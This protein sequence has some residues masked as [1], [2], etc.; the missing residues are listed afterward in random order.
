MFAISGVGI[1]VF[2]LNAP[3]KLIFFICTSVLPFNNIIFRSLQNFTDI[4]SYF[5]QII[6]L[7]NSLG[8]LVNPLC[9]RFFFN[10]FVNVF[11]TTILNYSLSYFLNFSYTI[12]HFFIYYILL[13][14]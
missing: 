14:N 7:N 5:P 8:H 9:N 1:D 10:S 13:S 6:I 4:F 2:K 3:S 12:P 11:I